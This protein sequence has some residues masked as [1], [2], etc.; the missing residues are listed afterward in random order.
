[1]WQSKRERYRKYLN[2]IE[3]RIKRR[4]VLIRAGYRCER[5]GTPGTGSNGVVLEVHHAEEYANL[6][7]EPLDE[8]EA[9]CDPCHEDIHRNVINEK[10]WRRERMGQRRLFDRGDQWEHARDREVL[11]P[12]A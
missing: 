9:L 6:G 4:Q 11:D 2:S 3:W 5:C 7:D 12:A 10:M 1:M 8:L